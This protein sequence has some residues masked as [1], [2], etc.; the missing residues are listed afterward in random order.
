M[1]RSISKSFIWRGFLPVC[2]ILSFVVCMDSRQ[3]QADPPGT[4]ACKNGCMMRDSWWFN[5]TNGGIKS[6][7]DVK[8]CGNCYFL[9]GDRCSPNYD[10]DTLIHTVCV[11][12]A[13]Q[14]CTLTYYS[15]A[16]EICDLSLAHAEAASMTLP[17]GSETLAFSFCDENR[18]NPNWRWGMGGEDD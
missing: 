1:S 4:A 11:A 3:L 2:L 13:T 5:G 15:Q 7:T 17:Y 16:F 18:T 12:H 9:A 6:G 10:Q 14:T 8:I